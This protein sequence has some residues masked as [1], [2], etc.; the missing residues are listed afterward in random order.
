MRY[1]FLAITLSSLTLVS[2]SAS[3][4]FDWKGLVGDIVKEVIKEDPQPTT[5]RKPA[6][7]PTSTP[8]T[9]PPP[10]HGGQSDQ[11]TCDAAAEWLNAAQYEWNS[12][13][14]QLDVVVER[15]ADGR[16]TFKQANS[17]A[18]I[19]SDSLF[20]PA[21]GKPFDQ[22]SQ[23]ERKKLETLL[24][25]D[26]GWRRVNG[27]PVRTN[28]FC[29]ESLKA[30]GTRP[31]EM[32]RHAG[33]MFRD[34]L[35]PTLTK[36]VAEMRE[37]KPRLADYSQQLDSLG[38]QTV[39]S[40]ARFNKIKQDSYY[41]LTLSPLQERTAFEAKLTELGKRY[42]AKPIQP[43]LSEEAA[44]PSDALVYTGP[45]RF[46]VPTPKKQPDFNSKVPLY[47][48]DRGNL[49]NMG[50]RGT[51]DEHFDLAKAGFGVLSCQYGPFR[52]AEGGFSVEY[53]WAN[54]RPVLSPASVQSAIAAGKSS[55]IALPACPPTY[56]EAL[57]YTF[58]FKEP[59]TEE[60]I[61]KQLSEA[62]KAG[63]RFA[64]KF[65]TRTD[66]ENTEFSLDGST[67]VEDLSKILIPYRV[68]KSEVPAVVLAEIDRLHATR[69]QLLQ[70]RYK[71]KHLMVAI[72]DTTIHFWAGNKPSQLSD[73]FGRWVERRDIPLVDATIKECPEYLGEAVALAQATGT[74]EALAKAREA[75]KL[76]DADPIKPVKVNNDWF[77][78][79]K[80]NSASV[81]TQLAR[82]L[83][84]A[85]STIE[86]DAGLTW[87]DFNSTVKTRIA[88]KLMALARSAYAQF[89]RIPA[90]ET[91]RV[92]FEK[93]DGL[94]A[95]NVMRTIHR[96]EKII[97]KRSAETVAV[98]DMMK[99]EAQLAKEQSER[100]SWRLNANI[101][102][103]RPIYYRLLPIYTERFEKQPM[104]DPA[105]MAIVDKGLESGAGQAPATTRAPQPTTTVTRRTTIIFG[106]PAQISA[107]MI[108]ASIGEGL[109]KA[110][111]AWGQFTGSIK[112]LDLD[113][114]NARVKFW[115]CYAK[116]CAD[117]PQLYREYST[118]LLWKDQHYIVR[119]NLNRKVTQTMNDKTQTMQ[120]LYKIGGAEEVD[121][122]MPV[123]CSSE[124]SAVEAL[125]WNAL[126]SWDG[127]A[128][129][130]AMSA[131]RAKLDAV[132]NS[133]T[134]A[135]WQQCRDKMEY[136]DRPRVF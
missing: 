129:P 16:P 43:M 42:A 78:D 9:P 4:G 10:T 77:V 41:W 45:K 23:A 85:V 46:A 15:T 80:A 30:K 63:Q 111:A 69:Q 128:S 29:Y 51:K 71:V 134:Y 102:F 73:A 22:L 92:A 26:G 39:E 61:A 37:A 81:D 84:N 124:Q 27:Q 24:T 56:G 97:A 136:L 34:H 123:H 125:V 114:R 38:G 52:G 96:L 70:C 89:D 1:Q 67:P 72:S 108:G 103:T 115:N 2:A 95:G 133:N 131:S 113:I 93:W 112:K 76:A 18:R 44:P 28:G 106:T 116:R 58:G 21:F 66:F 79:A 17:T 94:T 25:D 90:G 121:D 64:T 91:G 55:D 126:S 47:S 19:L 14:G 13:G 49:S 68:E 62:R 88:P 99:K 130:S 122:G 6:S 12:A 60:M 98:S 109:G 57:A 7:Q 11:L 59:P 120:T 32:A 74:K 33:L 117:A 20:E 132:F 5:E 83:E 31:V 107:Y 3:A 65:A 86:S 118:V 35:Q 110:A 105:F 50:A 135:T 82:D 87:Q 100:N 8:K 119:P 54:Q 75:A 36:M 101:Q 48:S 53:F 40:A 104:L 127:S